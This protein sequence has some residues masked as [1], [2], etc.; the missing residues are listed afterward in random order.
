MP[1]D[2]ETAAS[3]KLRVALS[4]SFRV[5]LRPKRLFSPS[6][7]SKP[8]KPK[9]WS[10]KMNPATNPAEPEH[11]EILTRQCEIPT[12]Q[13]PSLTQPTLTGENQI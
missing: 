2:T 8:N 1:S 9:P 11:R 4:A 12:R 3:K 7:P 10:S 5:D 13:N 6:E